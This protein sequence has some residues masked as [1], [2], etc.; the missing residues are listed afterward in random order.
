MNELQIFNYS[1]K[2][3]RTILKDNEPWW[4]LKDVS[5]ILELSNSRMV[6][7]RLEEDEVSQTYIT[8]NLGRQQE[9]TIINESG[10]YNVILRSDKPE[11]KA[12]KRWITHEVL[13]SIR[14]HGAYISKSVS[15][16]DALA[17]T[18]QVLQEQDTRIKQLETTQQAI[19]E[20]VISEPDNWRE[21]IRHKLNKIAQSIGSNKFQEVRTES[22]KL[23]EQRAG[24]NLERRLDN[25][26]GRMLKE[27][28][29]STA[30]SK[31]N[32]MD[33]IDEDKKLREIYGKIVSE[34]LIKYVA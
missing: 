30:I 12:F 9:T 20:A 4:V 1:D 22:Y 13:P 27:G 29:S 7:D 32:K 3:V 2:P 31:A 25:K 8:D 11:A 14:K 19:K 23:L 6:A 34:Y 24:V 16:L 33:V 18:V 21:D 26:R 15:A 17:Q 28:L 5:E 10:L